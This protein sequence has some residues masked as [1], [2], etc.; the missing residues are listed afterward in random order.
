MKKVKLIFICLF[1]FAVMVIVAYISSK[2]TAK[3]YREINIAEQKQ[4]IIEKNTIIKN[5][6][7][8]IDNKQATIDSLESREMIIFEMAHAPPPKKDEDIPQ[9]DKYIEFIPDCDIEQIIKDFLASDN[10][11]AMTHYKYKDSL[12][13]YA[14][15]FRIDYEYLT[16]D[17]RIKPVQVSFEPVKRYPFCLNVFW[18]ITSGGIRVDYDIWRIRLSP[19]I[20]LTNEIKPLVGIS[21]G[22]KI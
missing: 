22:F 19:A 9:V 18:N 21:I 14:V 8:E 7:M 17:F 2:I 15:D 4:N 5:A 1:A 10:R 20:G 12:N 16:Q 13:E 3:H 6:K 11:R